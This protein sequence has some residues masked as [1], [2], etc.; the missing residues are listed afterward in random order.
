MDLYILYLL[1]TNLY[2][3][4]ENLLLYMSFLAPYN[5]ITSITNV[6]NDL[7][8]GYVKSLWDKKAPFL[9]GAFNLCL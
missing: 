1:Q 6:N 4:V 3:T 7:N 8:M 5:Y 2:E 9:R